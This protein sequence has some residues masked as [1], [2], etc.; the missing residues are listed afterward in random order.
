MDH[1]FEQP[2]GVQNVQI[3]NSCAPITVG[4]WIITFILLAIPVVNIVLLF[5]WVFDSD[6]NPSKKSFAKAS[7]IIMA[8]LFVVSIIS[9]I[10]L[11]VV[12]VSIFISFNYYNIILF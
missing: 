11:F 4:Q 9:A 7:H 1:Q 3:V 10:L 5:I 6:T 8:V 2:N 12:G